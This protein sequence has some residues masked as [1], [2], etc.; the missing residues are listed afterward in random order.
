MNKTELMREIE[1]C[2]SKLRDNT[3]AVDA[4]TRQILLD[5]IR[6]NKAELAKIDSVERAPRRKIIT[7]ADA[8]TGNSVII[9][10]NTSNQRK[11][12]GNAGDVVRV[13]VR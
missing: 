10:T 9:R 7:I 3:R 6:A 11:I 4:A 13:S 5:T 8:P 12:I 1:D 2:R